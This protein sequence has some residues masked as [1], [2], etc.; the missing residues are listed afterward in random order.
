MA[1]YTVDVPVE[2]QANH[3]ACWASICVAVMA[4][5][6]PA[7]KT[8]TPNDLYTKWFNTTNKAPQ[9][10]VKILKEEFTVKCDEEFFK[11]RVSS[12]GE[13][14]KRATDIE[15]VI[16][17]ALKN[18]VP[19]ICGL[20]TFDDV[21]LGVAATQ[22]WKHAVLAY[23]CD[24]VRHVCWIRDPAPGGKN[25]SLADRLVTFDEMSSGFVYMNKADFG[26]KTKARLGLQEGSEGLLKARVFRLI[27]A[28]K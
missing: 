10:P 5:V 12:E 23:K 24:D 22:E 13:S 25:I 2:K 11:E 17:D 15:T 8:P 28:K 3:E 16:R 18:G 19:V 26:P 1:I 27:V 6:K 20:T 7:Q 4:G 14:A 21:K 9:D